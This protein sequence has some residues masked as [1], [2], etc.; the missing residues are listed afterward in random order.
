[1]EFSAYA[2]ILIRSAMGLSRRWGAQRLLTALSRDLRN[3]WTPQSCKMVIG[4]FHNRSR[5]YAL[6]ASIIAIPRARTCCSRRCISHNSAGKSLSSAVQTA[7]EKAL[8]RLLTRL[9]APGR[10]GLT[11]DAYQ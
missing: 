4:S 1:M 2:L 9:S 6:K 5:N 8:V 3:S 11:L 7:L 10:G